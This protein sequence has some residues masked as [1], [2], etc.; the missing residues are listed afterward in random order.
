[1]HRGGGVAVRK[2]RVNR[3]CQA[4]EADLI[5]VAGRSLWLHQ[6]PLEGRY[7]LTLCVENSG[8][9]KGHA[10]ETL[11]YP[12]PGLLNGSGLC[13]KTLLVSLRLGGGAA[14]R[15]WVTS[16]QGGERERRSHQSQGLRALGPE[17]LLTVDA[18]YIRKEHHAGSTRCRPVRRQAPSLPSAVTPKQS[19]GGQT[20]VPA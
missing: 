1:M 9:R 19:A 13:P 5:S 8:P 3:L 10:R 16:H 4:I 18:V 6:T 15:H 12:P 7:S 11:L 20:A 14:T 17:V 2:Q